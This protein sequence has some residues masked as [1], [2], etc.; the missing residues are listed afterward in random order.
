[1]RAPTW[2]IEQFITAASEDKDFLYLPRGIKSKLKDLDTAI[3]FVNELT[4]GHPIEVSFTGEL[5]GE[6]QQAIDEMMTT[7]MGIVSAPTGFGKTVVAANMIVQRKKSTLII[8]HSRVLANQWKER[9]ESFLDIDSEPFMEY[10]P[11]GRVRKKDKIGELHSGKESLSQNIDIALFQTLANRVD[12]EDYLESYGM[13]IVD[14]VHHAAAKT[15]EDVLKKV[16]AK[17]LYGL[18]ATPE[19]KDGLTPLLFMR[20][21]EIIYEKEF[22]ET[23][24]PLIA[25]FFYPRFTNYTDLNPELGHQ[26]HLT[27][28]VDIDER[29]EQIVSDI[30]ENIVENRTSLVLTERVA[31][32]NVLKERLENRLNEVSVFVLTSKL[33]EKENRLSVE[34]MTRE[35]RAFVVIATSFKVGEG[36]D[37]PKLESIFF[38]M[39]FSWKGRTTQY[40]GRLHR[41]LEDK[42]ELRVYDY[43]D[44]GVDYFARMYQKR[45]RVYNQLNYQLAEDSKTRENQTQLY[46]VNSYEEALQFDLAQAE[47]VVMGVVSV[48]QIQLDPFE[49]LRKNGTT[50]QLVIKE[51]KL[52]KHA[53]VAEQLNKLNIRIIP[54]KVNPSSFIVCDGKLIW[55]GNILFGLK[56]KSEATALRLLNHQVAEKMLGQYL[57]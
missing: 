47:K 18:T 28:M 32:A 8:V 52:K 6:Q 44:I 30:V 48:R 22:I 56:N 46:D 33:T 26:Q 14:E 39:P 7:N 35:K 42:D 55:Y 37:L 11:T 53:L 3:D 12:L 2:E 19:R 41:G 10:T 16:K 17:Y 36:F 38:T 20:F 51:E 29:N 31:H 57:I 15:F 49:Q 13:V 24:N 21:G 45:M 5:R 54:T 23:E 25:K 40:I 9:L 50:I 1:M 4:D 34:K 27:N 43:V